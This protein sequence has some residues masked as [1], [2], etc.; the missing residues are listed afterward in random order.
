[1]KW[2]EIIDVV[3]LVTVGAIVAVVGLSLWVLGVEAKEIALSASS[4]LG[5]FLA[6]GAMDKVR[7]K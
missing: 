6:K 2:Y 4:V 5:G 7:E 3:A 1:M